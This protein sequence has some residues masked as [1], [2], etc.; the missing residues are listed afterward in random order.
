MTTAQAITQHIK[1]LPEDARREVLD[2]VEFLELRAKPGARREDDAT[3]S[4]F[5]L[6]S[7][8]RGMENEPSQYTNADLKEAFR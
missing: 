3:W 5:S 8:M 2:F 7:A 1:A 4:S 6:T